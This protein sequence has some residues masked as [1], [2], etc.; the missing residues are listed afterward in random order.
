MTLESEQYRNRVAVIGGLGRMGA[1]T[2][3]IFEQAGFTPL[4]SDIKDPRTVSAREAIS[5]S[6]VVF[7]S[8]LPIEEVGKIIQTT[9][10]VFVETHHVLDNASLKNPLREGYEMLDQKG[11]SICS[12][13]PLCKEDQPLPGQTV[14]ILPFG[15]K[16]EAATNIAE[17]VHKEVGMILMRVDFDRHDFHSRLTQFLPHVDNWAVGLVLSANNVDMELL[18]AMAT[19]NSRLF[20]LSKWR[21]WVQPPEISA[22]IIRGILNL[23]EG[24]KILDDLV[25]SI[26]RIRAESGE[27]QRL[28]ET[29][30]D[31][32]KSLDPSGERRSVMNDRT[33]VILELLANLNQHSITIEIEGDRPGLLLDALALFK[34]A[35]I[36]LNAIASH[37][38]ETGWRFGIGIQS[39]EITPRI[40]EELLRL[41]YHVTELRTPQ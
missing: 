25:G 40:R 24:G 17:K 38:T 29:L 16:P 4:I 30:T 9:S 26:E 23:P 11:V 8:V 20:Y 32:A 35:G 1:V 27:P 36:N 7:F 18:D 22:T 14:L 33:I 21:T 39:G 31:V 13:H 41:S 6:S 34:T 28:E 12:T 15:Q 37:K 19:A 10:D 2:R 5:Q 3:R